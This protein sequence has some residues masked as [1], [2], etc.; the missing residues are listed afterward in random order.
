M[1]F[2]ISSKRCV[3]SIIVF[4]FIILGCAAK[5]DV[6]QT[7]Q[8]AEMKTEPAVVQIQEETI[9]SPSELT[10]KDI[11]ITSEAGTCSIKVI[12]SLP[13]TYTI[14]KLS[15]PERIIIDL[16]DMLPS[17]KPKV[18]DVQ[19]EFITTITTEQLE[20][21]GKN[22]LRVQVGLNSDCTYN[23]QNEDNS[24]VIN[25]S[26]KSPEQTEKTAAKESPQRKTAIKKGPNDKIFIQEILTSKTTSG[27][28]ITIVADA[29]IEKYF[30]SSLQKPNRLIIDLPKAQSMLKKKSIPVESTHVEKVRIGQSRD[31]V[32]V[33]L[34]LKGEKFP[35]YQIAQE[36]SNLNIS[37]GTE[38]EESYVAEQEEQAPDEEVSREEIIEEKVDEPPADQYTGEKI[39]LDFKDAD[40][41][42]VFRLIADISGLNIIVSQHVD[43]KVTLKL[44]S[45]PWDEALD[46]ILE[47]NNLG[48]IVTRSIM[49]IETI[50]QIKKINQEK[51]LAQ[52]SQENIEELELKTF[53]VSYAEAGSLAGFITKMKVLSSRGSVT[54][55]ALTNK[56]TVR[57]IQSNLDKIEQLI[58]EQDVPTRQVLIEA[59]IVQSNPSWVKELGVRW[60]GTFN[61]TQNGGSV[62]PNN[63]AD[64]NLSGAAGGTSVVNLPG[65]ANMGINFGYIKDNILLNVQ[66]TAME[67]DDKLKIISN[68]RILGLDNKEARIKQ[69]VALPYLKLSEEGVTSTEFKDAVLELTVTPKITPANTVALHIFVTKNQKSSQTGAGNEP[70]I[71]I[72]EVETDLLIASG[73]TVVIGGIYETTTSHNV[74]KVPFFGDLPYISRFF[75]N[76]KEE[77]Q[78]TELLVFLTVTVVQQ[79]NNMARTM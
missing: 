58:H 25:L 10:L 1:K 55:F 2:Q 37:I 45:I 49:R 19:N 28:K 56:L 14:F 38:K 60:G 23:A 43:G 27:S 6:K 65:P 72:R 36:T 64:I 47:T 16:P 3:L 34:D 26:S 68:P 59:K 50:E 67:N 62:A 48:K 15:N 71:D 17:D 40:I 29:D 30:S 39:S 33:V 54:A 35:L 51:L 7:E 21:D 44:D 31:K 32:R 69:G 12:S 73:K 46:L 70:G 79:P 41:K 63:G 8:S 11:D 53:D 61:T 74:H 76:E 66:L 5:R 9:P 77:E 13:P 18:L 42:N 57:D 22:F 4:T 78:I 20:D 24:I 75:K 52:K